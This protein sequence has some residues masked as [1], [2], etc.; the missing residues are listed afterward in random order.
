MDYTGWYDGKHPLVLGAEYNGGSPTNIVKGGTIHYAKI[1]FE[2]IGDEDCKKICSWIYDELK[3]DYVG[4]N[5]YYYSAKAGTC[6]AS[7][8]AQNLLDEA[9]YI[10]PSSSVAKPGGWK[11]TELKEWMNTKLFNG[12]SILWKQ[13]LSQ[14]IIESIQNTEAGNA[15]AANRSITTISNNYLYLPSVK[16][17]V[18]NPP[19]EE[20][21]KEELSDAVLTTYPIFGDSSEKTARIKTLNGTPSLWWLRSPHYRSDPG[22]STLTYWNAVSLDGSVN[23]QTTI[24]VTTDTSHDTYTLTVGYKYGICP[25]FSI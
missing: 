22:M 11:E 2:D 16:E 20:I 12:V 21:F 15:N 14:V 6:K 24:S 17:V 25:C 7:F 8:I 10:Y 19:S 18:T 13:I 4:S 23:N 1:W 5:R 3:F 9:R